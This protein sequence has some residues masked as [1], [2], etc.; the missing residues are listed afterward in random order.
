[1]GV[2][3][4]KRMLSSGALSAAA[5]A[6][7]GPK[8]KWR[9]RVTT[10]IAL[11]LTAWLCAST[12]LSVYKNIHGPLYLSDLWRPAPAL[13]PRVIPENASCSEARGW[14]LLLCVGWGGGLAW[15]GPPDRSRAA[16]AAGAAPALLRARLQCCPP[17]WPC[18]AWLPPRVPLH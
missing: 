8:A 5:V 1:M 12:Q 2:G 9:G 15:V 3:D 18:F 16:A 11:V 7:V 10:A 14:R 6:A 13:A 17:T 4:M